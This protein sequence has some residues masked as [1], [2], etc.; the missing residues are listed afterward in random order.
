M[1]SRT[2][3]APT[4]D[5]G[6]FVLRMG[7]GAT[8]LSLIALPPAREGPAAVLSPLA[9]L[10][11]AGYRARP[12]AA[13]AAVGWA[14]VLARDVLRGAPWYGLPVRA[15]LAV[16]LFSGLALTGPGRFSID[17]LWPARSSP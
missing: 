14:V 9:L 8:A 1:R 4:L 16:I 5:W 6:L 3:F 17:A 12:A 15:A 11:T 2:I 7:L 13:L 10:V